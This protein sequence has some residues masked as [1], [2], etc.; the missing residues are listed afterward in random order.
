MIWGYL[1]K[2]GNHHI[3]RRYLM[4]KKVS[5]LGKCPRDMIGR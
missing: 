4:E 5:I 3:E 1:L 2:S